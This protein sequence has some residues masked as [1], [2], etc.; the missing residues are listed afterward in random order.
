[1]PRPLQLG[2]LDEARDYSGD[3]GWRGVNMR[4][5][6]DQLET[7]FASLAVNYRFR[8]GTPEV[9]RGSMVIPWLNKITAGNIQPWGTVYGRGPFRD[10]ATFNEYELVAADGSVYACLANNAP[11]QLDLP[12][13][14]TVTARCTFLQAFNVVLLL[15]G[16]DADPL[17]MTDI[18]TGFL[19]VEPSPTGS[20]LLEIPRCL[21][22]VFMANRV[23]LLRE[24][25]TLV[26][27]DVN[28]Y[29]HFTALNDFRINQGE[30]DKAVALV[31]FGR[32]GLVVLKEKS[33][34]LAENVYGNLESL[35]TT[36]V[37]QRY[38][39]IA[40][41]SVVDCGSDVL[42]L[43]NE[44]KIGSLL[45]TI[46]NEV[47]LGQGA[48]PAKL[49]GFSDPLEPLFDRISGAY[50][51][52]AVAALWNDRYYIG[53]PVDNAE[54]F[55][56]ELI[57]SGSRVQTVTTVTGARYQFVPGSGTGDRI[58]N[59][60]ETI[61]T[62]RQFVAQGATVSFTT[63]D[64]FA[65]HA[66][67]TSSLVRVYRGE[68]N[69]L[70]H[71]DF[72]NQAWGGYDE[73]DAIA[74]KQIFT[75]TY[76]NRQRLFVSTHDG[77][78]RLWEEGFADR[79][80]SPYADLTVVTAPATGNT[81]RVN[82]GTTIT[83]NAAVSSNTG[84]TWGTDTLQSARQNLWLE[85]GDGG[86]RISNAARWTCPNAQPTLLPIGVGGYVDGTG[87]RFVATNGVLPVILTTGSWASIAYTVEQEI[88]SEFI[89]RGYTNP[90]GELSEFHGLMLDLQTWH[91][92]FSVN[93]LSDGINEDV[94]VAAAV[95]KD[96]TRYYF[97]F[98]AAPYVATNVNDDFFTAG[99]ED[100]SIQPTSSSYAFNPAVP[101]ATG[102]VSGGLLQEAREPWD[103]TMAGRSCRVQLLGTRGRHRIGNIRLAETV[104]DQMAGPIAS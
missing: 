34:Y 63:T 72:I 88:A 74:F 5:D 54:L 48:N 35:V 26:A 39:C 83:A 89:T 37:T 33:V 69:V 97:P 57:Q 49:P 93:L 15:R 80:S 102:G 94:V 3:G 85:T 10:P 55:G 23:F 62:A 28:D 9:R 79:L 25:D 56:I 96:R 104:D 29:T 100:Y 7:G 76:V 92:Q 73:A 45:L 32:T 82:A 70:A 36:S 86:F 27:S 38:G 58:V 18:N 16:F 81:L 61:T 4:L 64:I 41:E 98:D 43:T 13:G 84:A 1:M 51:A 19:A 14:V 60:T 75:G 95:T 78:V 103:V 22:G 11:I 12:A 40:P 66:I 87:I 65:T 8:D 42:W 50:A 47:Q 68:N 20:G 101:Q 59:G 31:R 44:F 91:G 90:E 77:Y 53:I 99:R 24:D 46:Q 17:V 30:A 2:P 21:R 67:T 6:P 52:N 71:Y